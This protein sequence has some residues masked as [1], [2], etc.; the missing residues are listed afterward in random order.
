MAKIISIATHKGGTG[1]TVTSISLASSLSR[2]G[3]KT[4]IIDLD[5]Q[6]HSSL[7][8][9]ID[10]DNEDI[11]LK[12]FFT[13]P[14]AFPFKRTIHNTYLENLFISPSTIRLA[15]ISQALYARTKR[16]EILRR[17]LSSVQDDFDFVVIDCPPTLGVLTETGIEASDLIL[18][19]CQMEAR[20]LD[21]FID[22]LDLIYALK[23]ENF[24]NFRILVTKYD[25]RK[26][27]TNE[28]VMSQFEEW[29][30][31]FLKTKIPLNESLNQAQIAGEDIFTFEPKSKG[32]IAY[33]ELA[34]ELIANGK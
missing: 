26:S 24:E 11:T 4:L 18:I 27:V 34:K 20:A 15:P 23:S 33:E 12:N 32:A 1:K 2:L 13:E 17:G 7:G 31:K 6:G 28:A 30:D 16:E 3:K 19:P 14:H 21:A 22:L 5:P 25:G 29:Q 10:I 9:G 8:L